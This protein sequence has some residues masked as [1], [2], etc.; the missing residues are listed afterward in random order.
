[1]QVVTYED[2][3]FMVLL[4]VA[5]QLLSGAMEQQPLE[6]MHHDGFDARLVCCAAAWRLWRAGQMSRLKAVSRNKNNYHI[7]R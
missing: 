3:P 2:L 4:I 1:M 6:A 5:I 7:C